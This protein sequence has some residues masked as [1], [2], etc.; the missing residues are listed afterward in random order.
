MTS[1]LSAETDR[2]VDR[3]PRLGTNGQMVLCEPAPNAFVL[4]IGMEP[5][6]KNLVLCRVADET[7]I[8]LDRF[9]EQ[10]RKVTSVRLKREQ[11]QLV[12]LDAVVGFVF[13]SGNRLTE[14]HFLEERQ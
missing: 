8:E 14:Q 6:G 10:R 5:L 4:Q 12:A 11:I 13:D 7:G 2:F 9:A 3:I 1:S